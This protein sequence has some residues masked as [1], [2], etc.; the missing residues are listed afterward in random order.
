M[1]VFDLCLTGIGYSVKESRKMKAYRQLL[2][3]FNFTSS[4]PTTRRWYGRVAQQLCSDCHHLLA[5][6]GNY[7]KV[8]LSLCSWQKGQ[9][10][11]ALR[12]WPFANVIIRRASP[13]SVACVE[14]M[15]CRAQKLVGAWQMRTVRIRTTQTML[16]TAVT[17]RY[18]CGK[19]LVCLSKTL[20]IDLISNVW[21][22]LLVYMRYVWDCR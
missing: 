18:N 2:I 17:M 12:N 22:R 9:P 1:T 6:D 16:M 3:A 4:E 19:Y 8:L 14:R 15:R 10:Q 20:A 13:T 21:H 7:Q 5:M 11:R